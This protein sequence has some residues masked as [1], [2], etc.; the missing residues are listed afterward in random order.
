MLSRNI[1]FQGSILV[2]FGGIPLSVEEA[3]LTLLNDGLTVEEYN[4]FAHL[5]RLGYILR[6][7]T[8]PY[9]KQ[10][11]P[12]VA[13]ILLLSSCFDVSQP[14]SHRLRTENQVEWPKRFKKETKIVEERRLFATGPWYLF[15]K[16]CK[17]MKKKFLLF[18][19]QGN[20]FYILFRK[21]PYPIMN[22][23][24]IQRPFPQMYL[25]RIQHKYNA[26]LN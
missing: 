22:P 18:T 20:P 9:W 17:G 11:S 2:R 19:D 21:V 13:R 4:V 1:L 23:L 6:P 24:W 25:T 10:S 3:Y 15:R 12:C 5:T 14:H 16:A 26:L 8:D 7:F